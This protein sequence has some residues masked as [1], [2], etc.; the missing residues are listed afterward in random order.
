MAIPPELDKDIDTIKQPSNRILV[1]CLIGAI[2]SL[3]G[4]I[5]WLAKGG[6]KNQE[7][8][9]GIYKAQL[10]SCQLLTD[11]RDTE[12]ARLN[13]YIIS[14]GQE[15]IKREREQVEKLNQIID[16]YKTLMK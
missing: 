15:D 7:M 5:V 4:V 12:I 13:N 1:R 14:E 10:A 8:Q 16:K 11:K 2:L 6:N 9:V 3:S